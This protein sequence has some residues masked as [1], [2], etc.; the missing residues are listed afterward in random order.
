MKKNDSVNTLT[1][2]FK[3]FIRFTSKSIIC[4][5]NQFLRIVFLY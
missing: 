5:I 1:S 3:L 2:Y 4:L